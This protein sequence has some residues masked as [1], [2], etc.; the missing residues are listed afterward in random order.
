MVYTSGI[1]LPLNFYPFVGV[2]IGAYFKSVNTARYLHD[3]VRELVLS[4][5]YKVL[6]RGRTVL[7]SKEDDKR[8]NCSV[9]GRTEVALPRYFLNVT[10][11]NLTH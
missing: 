8:P 1:L 4:T 11:R 5:W 2:A 10:A 9:H 7:P 3:K 6:M